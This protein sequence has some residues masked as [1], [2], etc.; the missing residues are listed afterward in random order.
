M[1]ITL[2]FILLFLII[3][4]PGIVFR[5]FYFYGD[6]S[7]QFRIKEPLHHLFISNIIPGV[8]L[9]VFTLLLLRHL[10]W[11]SELK[12][13]Y[14]QIRHSLIEVSLQTSNPESL[15]TDDFLEDI[16]KIALSTFILAFLSGYLISRTIRLFR[17]DIKYKLI[18]YKN[19]WYYLF[20]GE[21]SSF[22]KF[23]EN[24]N[25]KNEIRKKKF[26]Y[27]PLVDILIQQGSEK[28]LYS[29]VLLDYEV[30]QDNLLKL[31][32]VYLKDT[33]RYSERE[34][35]VVPVNIPGD[36]FVLDTNNLINININYPK[37]SSTDY[38]QKKEKQR[39]KQKEVLGF[40]YV[41]LGF[42]IIALF[43]AFLISFFINI[44]WSFYDSQRW[45]QKIILMFAVLQFISLFLPNKDTTRKTTEKNHT[46]SK[47]KNISN[48]F[49]LIIW[50]LVYGI[51]YWLT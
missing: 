24:L 1:Y 9:L 30:S 33:Q 37:I 27:P 48:F 21:I 3:I 18:R 29:G 13:L 10:D 12:T 11:I 38:L 41:L 42:I 34:G 31:E 46:K 50:S 19:G 43:V 20:S 22:E 44:G 49:W 32:R 45:F 39:K 6:F 35:K 25:L 7:K 4:L 16:S 51:I 15:I 28:L 5:R 2:N 40:F 26:F 47:S 36:L 8:V 17:L 14:P 23:K